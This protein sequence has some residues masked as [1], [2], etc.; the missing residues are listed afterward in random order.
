LSRVIHRLKIW[1]Y[2]LSKIDY[3]SPNFTELL[4][5]Q[6]NITSLHFRHT[7]ALSLINQLFLEQY[8][9]ESLLKEVENR[10]NK[11]IQ[12]LNEMFDYLKNLKA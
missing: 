2:D 10:V 7:F 12:K 6:V 5:T 4:K 8:D 11:E 1:G 3:Y 9:N